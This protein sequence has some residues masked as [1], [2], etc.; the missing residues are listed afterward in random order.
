MCSGNVEIQLG[1]LRRDSVT[2]EKNTKIHIN[3]KNVGKN[4]GIIVDKRERER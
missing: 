3:I 1:L 2:L 4:V